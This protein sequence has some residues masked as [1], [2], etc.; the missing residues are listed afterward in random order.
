MQ[1][2]INVPNSRLVIVEAPEDDLQQQEK[3]QK[4]IDLGYLIPLQGM[5]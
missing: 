2:L 3:T 1:L 4:T 5:N